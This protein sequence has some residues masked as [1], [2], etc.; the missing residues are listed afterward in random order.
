MSYDVGI[1]NTMNEKYGGDALTVFIF[2]DILFTSSL[3][4]LSDANNSI[5]GHI[6]HMEVDPSLSQFKIKIILIIMTERSRKVS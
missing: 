1:S 5:Q 2:G 6:E 4:N 3:P